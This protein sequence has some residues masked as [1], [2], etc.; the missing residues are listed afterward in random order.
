MLRFGVQR[1]ALH[2]LRTVVSTA[3]QKQLTVRSF[4]NPSNLLERLFN[5][6]KGFEK[7]FRKGNTGST[8]KETPLTKD[9]GANASK[10]GG[11]ES[12]NAVKGGKPGGTG[13]GNGGGDKKGD[14]KSNFPWIP[15]GLLATAGVVMM[16]VDED[17][18]S[19]GK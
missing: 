3:P 19:A 4:H 11:A 5:A 18:I 16:M 7:F 9:G 6:P 2:S 8:T 1:T 12:K 14:G 13:G 17:T 15:V 10:T